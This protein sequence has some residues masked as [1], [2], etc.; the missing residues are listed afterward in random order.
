[1][2]IVLS[3]AVLFT[4]APAGAFA[5]EETTI[6]EGTVASDSTETGTTVT[7]DRAVASVTTDT[8]TAFYETLAEAVAAVVDSENKTGTVELLEDASGSGIGLF[9]SEGHTGVD[10]TIDFNGHT[11]T[12]TGETVGSTGTESQVFHL[13]RDNKVTLIDGTLTESA[14][15]A[16]MIIQNYCDLTLDRM[17]VDGTDMS[18]GS[19]SMSNNCGDTLIKDS[20]IIADEGNV[21]FDVCDFSSYPGVTVTVEGDSVIQGKVEVT[22]PNGGENN[23]KLVVKGGTFSNNTV[24]IDYQ[25]T[26]PLANYVPENYEIVQADGSYKVQKMENKLVVT[27]STDEGKVSASLEGA[28][29][30]A[31]T[32]IEGGESGSESDVTNAGVTVDLTTSEEPDST[33]SAALTV[34]AETAQSLA[35]NNAPSLS[36]KTDV[37]TVV[38]DQTALG[39][40]SDVTAPVVVSVQETTTEPSGDNIAAEYTVSVTSDSKNLLPDG[41]DNGTVTITPDQGQRIDEV[42]VTQG[43]KAID[44]TDNSDSTYSFTMP[45][46]P[47]TITVTFTESDQPEPTPELP[48]NDVQEDD[49]YYQ[50]VLYVYNEGLMTGTAADTFSPGLT[51]TRGMI[52]SILHRQEG[53]PAASSNASF[54]DVTSGAYYE[55]AMNWAAAEGIVN[56]Y[57]DSAFGPNDAITR[58]QMAAILM[59]YA[60]YKGQDVSARADLSAYSDAESVSAWAE[61][62]MSWANAE[63]LIN[64]MSDTELAPKGHATRAQ[65]AAILQRFLA[66]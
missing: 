21:A 28:Y 10:L 65:V 31:D 20:T 38:L 49:W 39:K 40:M 33:T 35:Q 14:D 56:G 30:G 7:E 2:S 32:T 55:D 6:P 53:E 25:E 29:T 60:Q 8:G 43:S 34:T 54:S 59:N 41:D 19:Y 57:S 47:V 48:F 37:G 52:V 15:T 23:A 42:R 17:T 26:A 9:K 12:C 66:E 58:E 36:V 5:E 22:N 1:M 24:S 45:K 18:S 13:E 50:S 61:E 62:A 44:V 64:G 27:P 51:T 16:Y 63:G 11:Y 46:G 4:M 3:A